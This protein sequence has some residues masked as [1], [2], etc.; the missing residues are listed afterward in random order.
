MDIKAAVYELL[1]TICK[2]IWEM[3]AKM[4]AEA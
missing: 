2:M 1:Y 4:G 3:I